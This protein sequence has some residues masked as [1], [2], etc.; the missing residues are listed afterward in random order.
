MDSYK[1]SPRLPDNGVLSCFISALQVHD[2]RYDI[3]YYGLFLQDLPRR[4]GHSPALDASIK[5]LVTSYP[6]FHSVPGREVPQEVFVN[7]GNSLRVLRETLSDPKECHSPD[8][9]CAIYLISVT[10]VRIYVPPIPLIPDLTVN[11][12][13]LVILICIMEKLSLIY[14]ET[15]T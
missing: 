7:F 2:V 6:Y 3:T 12:A 11:R 8:T 9:L 14:F 15:W 5:S 13:G 1:I 4:L 10:Q